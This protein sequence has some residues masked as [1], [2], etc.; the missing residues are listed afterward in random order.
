MIIKLLNEHHLEFLSLKGACRGSAESTHVK[1]P[2]CWKSH[3]LAQL[4][5]HN[6]I[7][8]SCC[9]SK[10]TDLLVLRITVPLLGEICKVNQIMKFE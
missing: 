8:L 9:S 1:M 3:A 10:A 6:C 2:H 7:I 4:I 5:V